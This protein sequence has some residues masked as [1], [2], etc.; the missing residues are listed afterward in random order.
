MRN[1]PVILLNIDSLMPKPLEMAI[2]TGQAP[3][4]EFLMKKGIYYPNMVSSF[5]T[6][7]VTVDSSLLT[8]TY[9]DQHKIPGLNW[10]DTSAKEFVNYGTG[11]RET[12]RIGM[13]RSIH[14]MLY[15]L[16]HEHMNERVRTIYEKL[17]ARGIASASINSFVYRGNADHQ[18]KVPHL[19]KTL[20]RFEDGEWTVEGPPILS[21][22]AFSKIKPDHLTFQIAAGN[23]KYATRELRHLIRNKKLPAFTFCIF[24]DLDL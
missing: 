13:R 16:N 14:N 15:R 12:F 20:T 1:K 9:A 23:Y 11:F 22:G 7:S 17:A 6:M 24:Q 3:A 21:L 2:Q 18:L 10:F 4:L 19:L 8:G 5:P